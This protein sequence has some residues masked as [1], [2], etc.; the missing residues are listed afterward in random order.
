MTRSE[1]LEWCKRRALEYVDN[2]DTP[3]AY[4]SFASDMKEHEETAEHSALDVGMMLLMAGQ[5]NTPDAMRKF[6][7]GF[8]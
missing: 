1:H 6:I 5:L 2:G 3:Q 4:A 8:N 7:N